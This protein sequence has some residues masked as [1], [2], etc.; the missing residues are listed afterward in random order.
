MKRAVFLSHLLTKDTPG[1][2]GAPGFFCE[3]KASIAAGNSA[4]SSEWRLSNH[5]GT[6]IDVPYHFAEQGDTIDLY[7]AESWFFES[8]SLID[9]PAK[10]AELILPGDWLNALPL[11]SDLLLLRTSFEKHRRESIYWEQ[12]PGFSPELGAWLRK[13]RP[14]LRAIGADILSATS[15]QHREVGRKAH[16]RFLDPALAGKPIL[17]IEDMALQSL[18]KSPRRVVVAPMRVEGGDGGPVTVIAE[19]DG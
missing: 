11:E 19:V 6:H 9:Y 17:I 8:P 4:N 1:Y 7:P 2:G 14:Q 12:N 16:L 18:V 5:I 10:P 15:W 3:S 13:N